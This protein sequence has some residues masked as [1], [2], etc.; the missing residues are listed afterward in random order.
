[1][2]L[3]NRYAMNEVLTVRCNDYKE[4]LKAALERIFADLDW[5]S[6]ESLKGKKIL[7]KPNML[8]DRAPEQ[9]V[10]THP[11]VLRQVIRHLKKCKAK[12]TVGDSPASCSQ[13]KSGL[14]EN[15]SGS[16]L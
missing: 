6:Y 3:G 4:A 2:S 9:A 13:S 5:L 1:M 7:V 16:N 15:R 8:T 12:I 14:G 10:T 11:E